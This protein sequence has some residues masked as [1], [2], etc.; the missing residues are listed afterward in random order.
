MMSDSARLLPHQ[1]HYYSLVP[2]AWQYTAHEQMGDGLLKWTLLL[3]F[4]SD[5]SLCEEEGERNLIPSAIVNG[6]FPC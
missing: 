1:Q 3:S 5:I 6:Y 2:T 4:A